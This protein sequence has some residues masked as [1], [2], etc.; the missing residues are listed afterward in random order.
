MQDE[1]YLKRVRA[2]MDTFDR[3]PREMRDLINEEGYSIVAQFLSCGVRKPNQIRHLIRV[4]RE[5][6]A[7]YSNGGPTEIKSAIE[8][9]KT[10]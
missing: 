7:A 1:A 2:R 5:G 8:R 3:L 6:S 10:Q 9:R 4:V